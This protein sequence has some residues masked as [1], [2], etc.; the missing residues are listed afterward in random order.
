MKFILAL[1]FFTFSPFLYSYEKEFVV[2]QILS[3]EVIKIE[4]LDPNIEIESG[5]ILLIYSHESKSVLGYARAELVNLGES[6]FTATIE[7]HGYRSN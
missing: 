3:D 1:S 4:K 6:S 7:T 2:T 5:D